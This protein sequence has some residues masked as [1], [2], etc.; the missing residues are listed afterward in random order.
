MGVT[1]GAE[2]PIRTLIVDDEP[3][4]RERLRLMLEDE[5]G[6]E[7]VGECG[8]GRSASNAIKRKRPDLVLLDIQLPE[9]DGFEIL[10]S[11]DTARP[12]AIVFVTA[13][14]Q[15][16]LK[17]FK[18]HALDYLLKPVDSERLHQALVRVRAYKPASTENLQRQI[19]QLMHVMSEKR[20]VNTPIAVKTDTEVLFFRA[21]EIDWVESAGG[22]VCFHVGS[23]TH[24]SRETMH[25]VEQNLEKHNFIRIHRSTIVNVDRIKK[26]K[27]LSYG[28]YGVE[29]RDGTAL[30]ISRGCKEEVLKKIG[31]A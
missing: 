19:S 29:L 15:F 5:C 4:A 21:S 25:Q 30:T 8:D 3:L 20:A 27:S 28:E 17:A 23:Q 10:E 12:P 1:I 16:A 11:M 24:I 22:Y 6:V 31:Y 18:V 2:M 7:V 13:Y 26:L 9:M 14:D